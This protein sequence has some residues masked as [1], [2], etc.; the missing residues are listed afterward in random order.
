[1]SGTERAALRSSFGRPELERD[2]RAYLAVRDAVLERR[3]AGDESLDAHQVAFELGLAATGCQY[4]M[5]RLVAEGL[6]RREV[7]RGH[8][9]VPLGLDSCDELFDARGAM[10]IGAL[11]IADVPPSGE[12]LAHLRALLETMRAS[13]VA[14]RFIDR[15]AYFAANRDFHLTLVA[16]A[17]SHPLSSAFELVGMRTVVASGFGSSPGTSGRFIDAQSDILAGLEQ[18]DRAATQRAV[19]AYTDL[20]KHR[21][22]AVLASTG[23][24]L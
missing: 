16:L 2:E 15:D 3:W 12:V 6:L 9:V 18:G 5:T 14:D 17:G 23:G 21:V 22:R 11:G 7:G 4:A 1:M 13:V 24:L 19:R 20:A 8:V 10:T